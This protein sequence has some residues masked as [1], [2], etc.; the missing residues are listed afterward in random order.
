MFAKVVFVAFFFAVANSK[1]LFFE[2]I[3]VDNPPASKN[4]GNIFLPCPDH[5]DTGVTISDVVIPGCTVPP[6]YVKRGQDASVKIT[7]KANKDFDDLVNKVQ[8]TVLGI[9]TSYEIPQPDVCKSEVACPIKAQSTYTETSMVP[10]KSVYPKVDVKLEWMLADSA[11]NVQ[12]CLR[13]ELQLV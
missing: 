4:V 12:G 8:A 6:C 3:I 2:K 7:F 10:I 5:P 13:L 1:P 11:G 9:T